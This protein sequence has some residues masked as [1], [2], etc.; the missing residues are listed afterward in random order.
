[1]L[2]YIWQYLYSSLFR[3]WLKWFLRQITGKCELQRICDGYR[4][5]VARTSRR[6]LQ[7]TLR[8]AIDVEESGLEQRVTA[9][10]AEKNIRSEKDPMFKTNLKVCLLQIN[11]YRKLY[12]YV[13]DL[14]KQV[15]ESEKKEHEELLL[16][17]WDLLMPSVKLQSRITKQWG[18]I[19]FQGDDPKT[20]FR[21][22]GM[23]GLTNLVFFSARYTELSRQV[24]SHA[25]HPKLG[26]SYAIV[27]I[28]LTE[29][30]YSLLKSGALKP[31]FYN[32]V[33]G[34]PSLEHF[35]Q[36]YCYLAYEF[37]KFWIEEEPASIMEFNLYRERF[38]EKVKMLLGEPD[39]S[40]SLKLT[41]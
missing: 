35:H 12:L 4:Q 7:Q 20:D 9:I 1:M 39:V 38:H 25:N 28:N 33:D 23:L 27:G 2:G 5:G 13:E 6:L 11:G 41:S 15:F 32:T 8:T 26:Y 17:L 36:L 18:D 40:L 21:G 14:R 3:L 16:K 31:H 22:M 24:L 37:D 19:G 29:M 10:M 34:S 30:A